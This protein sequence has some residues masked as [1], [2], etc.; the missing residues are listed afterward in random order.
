MN[1]LLDTHVFLWFLDDNPQL[2][3]NAKALTEDPA[4][5]KL[6]SVAT[7]SNGRIGVS[8]LVRIEL[9]CLHT[10]PPFQN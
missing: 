6:V 9:Y 2:L 1:L 3:P 10:P 4:N 8:A 5:C 7:N